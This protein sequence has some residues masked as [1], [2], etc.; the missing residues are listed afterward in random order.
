MHYG[1]VL[2]TGTTDKR[3]PWIEQIC[4]VDVC[5]RS[6]SK[7]G[8]CSAHYVR[9]KKGIELTS[10]I[11]KKQRH[12]EGKWVDTFGYVFV[13]GKSEHRLV[14]EKMLGRP[15]VRG[16]NV[17]HVNGDRADNRPEN[18][19]LWSRWQP[20]GQR[21]EDKV[22]WAIELLELYRPDALA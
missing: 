3:R 19:E 18:L 14:M 11:R 12:G 8:Y 13:D 21:V 20:P 15:L 17:H 5:S 4:S 7:K 10:P 1:R 16:E 9:L 6:A 2:R 22:A